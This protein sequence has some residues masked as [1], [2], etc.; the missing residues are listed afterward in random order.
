MG[1][2]W[3]A[4]RAGYWGSLVRVVWNVGAVINMYYWNVPWGGT[5]AMVPSMIFRSRTTKQSS[6]VI[7]QKPCRRS[8]ESAVSLIRTSVMVMLATG[9]W[10]L[11]VWT[12]RGDTPTPSTIHGAA[13][14][15]KS[16]PT[17]AK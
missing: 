7:E 11:A 1:N 10:L 5:L 12:T 16:P 17:E 9:Y 8:S 15:P 14:F 4:P 2:R 13:R 3:Y 6:K